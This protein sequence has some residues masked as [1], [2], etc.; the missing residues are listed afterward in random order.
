MDTIHNLLRYRFISA[1]KLLETISGY[2]KVYLQS[3][4]AT[5]RT[6]E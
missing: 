1:E 6:Q 4:P 5:R 3:T 2:P